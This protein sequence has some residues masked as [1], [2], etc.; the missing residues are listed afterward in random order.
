MVLV[1]L[2]RRPGGGEGKGIAG[3]VLR[4]L[5][6]ARAAGEFGAVYLVTAAPAVAPVAVFNRFE[7]VG[8]AETV[9]MVAAM[10]FFSMAMFFV[11]QVVARSIPSLHEAEHGG[12]REPAGGYPRG[13]P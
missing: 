7:R 3:R 11:L 1:G 8:L 10:I 12:A 5:E 9:P 2:A 6:G 4:G 13:G